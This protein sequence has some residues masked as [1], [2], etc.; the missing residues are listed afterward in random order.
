MIIVDE[1]II[2]AACRWRKKLA[3]AFFQVRTAAAARAAPDGYTLVV[4]ASGPLAVNQA[5]FANIGYDPLTAFEPISLLATLANIIVVN[6]QQPIR[7]ID[8]LVTA[9]KKNPGGLNY[10]SIG[11]GG[12]PHLAAV[13][14]VTGTRMSHVPYRVTGQLVTDLVADQLQVSFQLI[15]NVIGQFKGGLLRRLA[16]TSGKRS[17]ILPDVPTTRE[18][19]ISGYEA[20]GWFALLAPRGRRPR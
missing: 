14:Q 13:R 15:P 1:S 16:E 20:Y 19:G 4:T 2:R 12:S 18:L 11:N 5:L 6:S 3:G 17:E 8:D 7:S 9:A 10:G